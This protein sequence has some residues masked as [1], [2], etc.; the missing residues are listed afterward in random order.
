MV[1]RNPESG[2]TMIEVMIAMLIT[3]IALIGILALFMAQTKASGYSRHATE[4]TALCE[5]KLEKLRT[6]TAAS[7]G[8]N[9][10]ETT[11]D[12]KGVVGSGIYTRTWTY[13]VMAAYVD[14]VCTTSW[15][16]DEGAGAGSG[17]SVTLRARRKL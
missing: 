13:T 11:L 2:F 3:A 6:L 12:E 7:V 10:T 4:A 1:K 9:G 16:E 15:N 14:L 5:D 8:I 17:K